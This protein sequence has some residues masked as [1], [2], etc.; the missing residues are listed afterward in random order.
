[1]TAVTLLLIMSCG[2]FGG[3]L[4][5]NSKAKKS[6]G[7]EVRAH[8]QEVKVPKLSED[9]EA[10]AASDDLEAQLKN[11]FSQPPRRTMQRAEVGAGGGF[12][13]TLVEGAEDSPRALVHEQFEALQKDDESHIAKLTE[14]V[15]IRDHL[16]LDLRSAVE[17]AAADN[18][19]ILDLVSTIPVSKSARSASASALIAGKEGSLENS[20]TEYDSM[21]SDE[22][23][24]SAH[25]HFKSLKEQI[26]ALRAADAE[27][28]RALE[29]NAKQR[30]MFKEQIRDQIK[31]Q[32]DEL[33]DIS[34]EALGA[35]GRVG[36]E[37][38]SKSQ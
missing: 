17:R 11:M 33:M 2:L 6:V 35:L 14:N 21:T 7:A 13:A 1:M 12:A 25:E 27:E 19:E 10:Q 16:R 15:R 9:A 23:R 26:E 38:S 29:L 18:T 31:A 37:I 32:Q 5:T 30:H 4:A 8:E 3:A 24:N 22:I 20:N 36:E 28:L 34:T